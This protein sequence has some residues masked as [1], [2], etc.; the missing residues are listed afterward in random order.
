MITTI[1]IIVALVL[2]WLA[3]ISKKTFDHADELDHRE[4]KTQSTVYPPN[5]KK[6]WY[7]Y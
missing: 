4:I 5:G 3:V 7:G 6:E 2:V 1:L